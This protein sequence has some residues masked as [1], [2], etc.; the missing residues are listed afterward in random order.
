MRNNI[1]NNIGLF[2]FLFLSVTGNA[3]GQEQ[4]KEVREL[5]MEK[6]LFIASGAQDRTL[7]I[8]LVDCILYAFKSNSDILVQ[9]IEPK[10]RFDDVRIAR[11]AFEPTLNLDFTYED[12]TVLASSQLQGAATF[13]SLDMNLNGNVSGKM[14]TGTEYAFNFYNQRYKSD[15][16]FQIFNPYYEVMPQ[17]ILTQPLLRG[18]GILVNRADIIIA[19]NNKQQ[20]DKSFKQTIIDTISS[21]KEAYFNYV[22]ALENFAIDKLA[23]ERVLDLLEIDKARYQK[24]L[25]SSVALLE[26]EAAAADREKALLFSEAEIKRAEDELKVITNIIDD[27]ETWNAKIEL[28]DQPEFFEEK[29]NLVEC[30]SDA[31]KFRPDYESAIIGLRNRDIRIKVAKNALLPTVDLTGSFGLNGLGKDYTD[32]VQKAN[33]NYTDWGMGV[34]ISVPWGGNER[35]TF[36]Q[37]KLEKAQAILSLKKLEHDIIRDVRDRIRAVDTQSRQVVVSKISKEKEEQNYKAQK[38]RFASGE[39][40]THD[41]LDYQDKLSR[42]ELDY[43]RALID[44][45][46]AVISLDKSRGITL[47][48]NNI[49]LEDK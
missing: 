44:Y 19:Q 30:L 6:A 25:I 43:I 49:K 10:L 46:I 22:F 17:I 21:T 4:D 33:S 32:A 42:A 15:S 47:S 16:A 45:N 38:E 9:G 12:N 34:K 29:T 18:F 40:S 23:L 8:G 27:P 28:L 41:M 31:F 35:A 36:D 11:S 13:N 5:S 20:A 48:R 39:V 7:K 26:T 24:G 14:I 1:F 2:L 3:F 37:R